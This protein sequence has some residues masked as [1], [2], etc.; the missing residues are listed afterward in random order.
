MSM[1]RRLLLLV[2]LAA[3]TTPAWA[4]EYLV[5]IGTYTRGASKGIYAYKLDDATGKLT[6]LGLAAETK[7]PSFV[8]VHPS[9]K[10]LY[11]VGESNDAGKGGAV[12][13]YTI[14]KA[15]GKLT[16]INEQY[17]KGAG[18]CHIVID[19]TG[20][21][22]LVANYGGGSVISFP[23]KPDGSLGEEASFHQH[24]GTG[25]D[26]R[27]QSGPHTHSANVS[28][29]N[30]FAAVADLGLDEVLI[31]K[32]DPATAKLTPNE[33]PFVKTPPGGGPR[34]FA[35]HPSAKFAYVVNEMK[36][37]VTAFEWDGKNGVLK[38]IQTISTLPADWKGTGNSNAEV[39]VHPAGKFLYASNRG[40]DSI[41]VFTIDT[42]T[43]KL[44]YVENVSTQG[45]TPRNFGVSPS[46][47]WVIAA[48]QATNNMAVYK[49]DLKT[50]KLT[51]TG[52]IEE[53]GS[54]VCVKFLALK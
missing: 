11:S 30:R 45:K 50:G 54:P 41:A 53:V 34:H 19:K 39:Q 52:Q 36:S 31:Y 23:V 21:S 46:G 49:V 48:N 12:T 25:A 37:A 15:T 44:T 17:S 33:P 32:L 6:P 51:P 13:A 22:A 43:G 42:K 2:A 9:G 8:A 1:S 20:R 28:P 10:Y 27:R 16:K 40:H 18:P 3:V 26:P 5:Y 7:D 38:E 47:K 14:D 29:D 24:K 35:F 4:V